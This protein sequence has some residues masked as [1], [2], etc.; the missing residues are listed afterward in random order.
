MREAISHVLQLSQGLRRSA[1]MH[2][3]PF[4]ARRLGD[5]AKKS[6]LGDPRIDY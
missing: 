1:P 2:T 6:E 5:F 3:V 4:K